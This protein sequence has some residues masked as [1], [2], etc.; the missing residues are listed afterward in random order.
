MGLLRHL[1]RV[2][3]GKILNTKLGV[4]VVS[5]PGDLQISLQALLTTHLDVDVLVVSEGTSALNVI[6]R[7]KP[8][9]VI[10][11]QDIF[12]NKVVEFIENIKI[13]WPE[14]QCVVLANDSQTRQEMMIS[15][16]DLTVIKG[17]PGSKLV[18][19]IKR[20]LTTGYSPKGWKQ[21]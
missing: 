6:K 14:I 11:D 19:E 7:H 18:A 9:L 10:L 12:K 17:F 21:L 1:L 15:S 13:S 4:L 8:A 3:K 2:I 20:L 16:A 5:P